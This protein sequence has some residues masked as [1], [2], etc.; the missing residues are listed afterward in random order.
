M[1]SAQVIQFPGSRKTTPSR[2]VKSAAEIGFEALEVSSQT[3]TDTCFARDDLRE[4]LQISPDKK[5]AIANR[6][7]SLRENFV[8]AQISLT[9]LLKQMGRT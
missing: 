9:K 4:M 3:Q 1:P 2:P 6:I 8:D 7:Y 5:A